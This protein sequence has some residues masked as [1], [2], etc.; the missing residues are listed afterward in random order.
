MLS[1]KVA[2]SAAHP[3][4]R[5]SSKNMYIVDGNGM[6]FAFKR[7]RPASDP[8]NLEEEVLKHAVAACCASTFDW[9]QH[10]LKFCIPATVEIE[11]GY[12]AN[13][14]DST[15]WTGCTGLLEP[16]LDGPYTKFLFEQTQLRSDYLQAFFTTPSSI[17]AG[18]ESCGTYR[19][20]QKVSA[21][22]A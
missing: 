20:W 21:P 15:D 10:G 1:G 6:R 8:G 12:T 22:I 5:G 2:L 3:H 7:L 19:V 16:F 9:P 4:G 17:W 18:R 13:G 11:N 14:Q